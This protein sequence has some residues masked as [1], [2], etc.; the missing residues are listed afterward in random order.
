MVSALAGFDMALVSSTSEV[1]ASTGSV[2]VLQPFWGCLDVVF[3]FSPDFL[4]PPVLVVLGG[5][6]ST[7]ASIYPAC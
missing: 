7:G 2:E 1:V 4:L 3:L 5:I 6:T